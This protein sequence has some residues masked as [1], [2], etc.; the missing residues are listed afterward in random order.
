MARATIVPEEENNIIS[1]EVGESLSPPSALRVS[2]KGAH[3]R[4]PRP[5]HESGSHVVTSLNAFEL[6][7]MDMKASFRLTDPN[8]LLDVIFLEIVA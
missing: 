8:F 6:K 4:S 1:W 7:D 5:Q 2:V 3:A